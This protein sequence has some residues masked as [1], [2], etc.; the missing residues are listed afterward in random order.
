MSE[1]LREKLREFVDA[2]ISD[3]SE[4]DEVIR[5][6]CTELPKLM[7][8]MVNSLASPPILNFKLAMFWDSIG[9]PLRRDGKHCPLF[10]QEVKGNGINDQKDQPC[11]SRRATVPL[12]P[13]PFQEYKQHR[14]FEPNL[15]GS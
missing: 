2:I 14:I 15:E 10:E 13:G 5:V 9:H 7:D 8:H 4:M 12:E 3:L 11:P 1:S 6:Q